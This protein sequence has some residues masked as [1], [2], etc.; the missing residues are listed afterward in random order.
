[1]LAGSQVALVI[2]TA[3]AVEDLPAGRFGVISLDDPA[4]EAALASPLP[5]Q[6]PEQ[7]PQRAPSEVRPGQLAYVIYTSGSTGVPK[8]VQVTQ[9]GLANYVMSVPPRLGLAEPGGRYLL[10]QGAVTD[11]GN[12]MI[13]ASLGTGGILHV[14]DPRKSTDADVVAGYL[15]SR[16]IDY[17]KVVP[18]HLAA[19]AGANAIAALLPAR[20]LVLGGEPTPPALAADILGA[21]AGRG[22]ANHYGPTETT[23]G[24]ATWRLT[25]A[26]ADRGAVPIGS[27][28]ANTR[29]YV[30]DDLLR[31]VP[32]GVPGEL[33]VAGASLARGYRGRAALTAERFLACPFGPGGERMYRTGDVVRWLADGRLTFCGRADSQ[34]KVRGFRIELGE[35]EAALAAHPR[36]VQAAAAVREDSPGHQQLVGYVVPGAAADDRA[37]LVQAV[38]AQVAGRLPEY[39]VP[40]AVVA[41]DALPLTPNGKLDR[42]A[43]P[44]P[45]FAAGADGRGPAT[46]A[47]EIVCGVF[48]ELLGLDRVGV[49]DSFFD[50]GGHSLLATRLVSRVRSLLGTELQIREVFESPTPAGLAA[51]AEIAGPARMALTRRA[52]PERIP[53]S[54]AQRRLW[55]LWQLEGP[56]ATYNIPLAVRLAGPLDVSALATALRDVIGRHE[57]L[58]TVFPAADGEPCQRILAPGDLEWELTPA[59]VAEAELAGAVE[60]A[61][62]YEFD[63]AAGLPLRAWLF[64]SGPGEQVLV[65]VLHHIAGDG[66]SKAALLGDIAA[67][68][69]ARRDGAAAAWEPLPVQYADYALWQR[70]L[71]GSADDPGSLLARQVAYWRDALAGAPRELALPLDHPRS[72]APS[73]R[74]HTVALDV[75]AG[76]HERLSALARSRGVTLFMVV[77]AAL[78][79]L[80]SKL[81][82]GPDIPV[83]IAVAGRTDAALDDLVGFFVNTLVLRADLSQDA[84]FTALL[85][86]VRPTWL[87]ALEHQDVPFEQLVEV[88]APPRSLGRHPL[89]QVMLAMQNDAPA[90]PRLA[91]L[92]ASVLPA[93]EVAAKFDLEFSLSE[94]FE[95]G[96]PAGL[97]GGMV[98]AADLFDESSA[99]GIAA[100]YSR[101]LELLAADPGTALHAVQI[102]AA[103]ERRQLVT[104]WNQT[105]A[106]VPAQTLAGLFEAQAA[107]TPD[108]AAVACGDEWLGYRELNERANRLARVLVSRGAGPESVVAVM[109][110]R[111]VGLVVSLLAVV[112][113]GAAY[114]PVDPGYPAERIALMLDDVDPQCV[115]TAGSLAADHAELAGQAANDLRDGD[116]L[117]ALTP[118]HPA[119]VIYT[120]GSTGVPKGVA[121]THAGIVNRLAWMQAEY[122][123][124]ADDRVLQKT[125]ISFD[126]S[127]W[128]LFW[129]LLE[130][131]RLVLA[132]PGGH[133]DPAYLSWLIAA[134]GITTV[135]FVPAHAG[136]VPQRRRAGGGRQPAPGDLQRRGPAGQAGRAGRGELHGRAA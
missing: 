64:A 33:Y 119:Y 74:G 86:R 101:V 24:V 27:P 95:R 8:G 88:L 31:P 82:A 79:V 103:A 100:R 112:K 128:E 98:A 114:V 133:R 16:A 97:R 127:V 123:L 20:T 107:R 58:R 131:G 61:A 118:A 71:L 109:L 122:R 66:L 59:R 47:E 28:V 13:F 26:D 44:A 121:I 75:P 70:E 99:E 40:A 92:Q 90:E 96:R 17:L 4:V 43:L 105:A 111:S 36:V 12:T 54:F 9:G 10:L 117:S 1:M 5:E 135:H 6:T 93:G 72:A 89:F 116:R 106:P 113:A 129:P 77:Q 52:R 124:G 84:P 49:Q 23:I 102:V 94:A 91:G 51:R 35:V 21:A 50:L 29:L 76:T 25:R 69:A 7:T 62:R 19:L 32:P 134:A 56:S 120:S 45:S 55:F 15:A 63:L 42:K 78:A 65:L 126:V 110:E 39:M 87:G 130:G 3:A 53:L 83:G 46:V 115:L 14:L 38:R 108:A 11:F 30:L 104:G 34:V 85:D 2:G 41:L 68:Y 18:S 67:A 22:V 136:G 57:V 60:Q 80:L 48:A 132:R 125:P 37:D 81:G 73:Y